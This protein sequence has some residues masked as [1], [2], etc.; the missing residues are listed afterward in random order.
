M[1]RACHP[2]PCIAVTAFTS[3]LALGAGRGAGTAWVALAV[4][5]GHVSVGWSND[6][7]DA[8]RDRVA[9]R[10]DKPA[11]TGEADPAVIRLA[12]LTALAL[13]VP[14]SLLAGG[15]AAAAVHLL[16]VGIAW[17][18]NLGVKATLASPLPYAASFALLPVFVASTVGGTAPRWTVAATALLGAGA[19]FTNALP[20]L[21]TDADSGV[22]GLPHALGRRVSVLVAAVLLLAG[23]AVV[24]AALPAGTSGRAAAAIAAVLLAGGAAL[25][26]RGTTRRP[27]LFTMLGAGALVLALVASG[28]ALA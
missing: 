18:Y 7:L 17:A 19:H 5:S 10:H 11:V 8:E 3:A 21:E 4:L 13:C 6:W 12:A 16:A 15:L 28:P 2:A 25:G 27:F 14:L 20:D 24:A 1:L 22:R 23:A 9:S 26:L